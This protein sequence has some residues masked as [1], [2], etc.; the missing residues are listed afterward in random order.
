MSPHSNYGPEWLSAC[1]EMSNYHI[2]EGLRLHVGLFKFTI[3]GFLNAPRTLL[4]NSLWRTEPS[5]SCLQRP[6]T[7][8]LLETMAPRQQKAVLHYQYLQWKVASAIFFFFFFNLPLKNAVLI[9]FSFWH[10]PPREAL[11]RKRRRKTGA[12]E[13]DR[14]CWVGGKPSR[15]DQG[16]KIICI[17]FLFFTHFHFEGPPWLDT[18][19]SL[20]QEAGRPNAALAW[21]VT[22]AVSKATER[23]LNT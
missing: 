10:R 21:P 20:S 19:L 6:I 18:Q 22:Q 17:L 5:Y 1:F 4:S 12:S 15:R 14:P 7:A 23:R 9:K 16:G 3:T 2:S 13:H 8:G 11:L